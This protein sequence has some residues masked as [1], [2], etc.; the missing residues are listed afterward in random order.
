ML[1]AG[2]PPV[3]VVP[4]SE[5]TDSGPL[6]FVAILSVIVFVGTVVASRVR[7]VDTGDR[8]QGPSVEQPLD[9]VA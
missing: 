2:V 9:R 7:H 8:G 1:G 5:P 3:V 6:L 4:S